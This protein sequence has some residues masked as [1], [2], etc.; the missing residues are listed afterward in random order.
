[1]FARVKVYRLINSSVHGKIGLLITIQVQ[2]RNVNATLNRVLPNRRP[3]GFATNRNLSRHSDIRRNQLHR[4]MTRR[5]KFTAS[6]QSE[7]RF[8]KTRT[9]PKNGTPRHSEWVRDYG[10][11]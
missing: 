10:L 6:I 3:H 11:A 9:L 7:V 4:T 1:M 2:R 5:T 8:G